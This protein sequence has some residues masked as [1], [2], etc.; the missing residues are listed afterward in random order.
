MCENIPT[1]EYI[2]LKGHIANM[3]LHRA[4]TKR[5][6][7]TLSPPHWRVTS[8]ENHKFS[9]QPGVF[10]QETR[11]WE[12]RY[13]QRWHWRPK[14]AQRRC[15]ASLETNRRI[16]Q[17]TNQPVMV[18]WK[19]FHFKQ[20]ASSE[21]MVGQCK[22]LWRKIAQPYRLFGII[23]KASAQSHSPIIVGDQ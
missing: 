7:L 4:K 15:D 1:L 16:N 3:Y 14:R 18:T 13:L 21:P 5:W 2:H 9:N 22:P 6:A 11:F 17:P 19:S 12:L 20:K 23:E 8:Y 10:D